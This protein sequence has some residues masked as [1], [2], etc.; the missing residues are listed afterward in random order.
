V[1]KEL[2]YFKFEPGAWDTGNIQMCSR[3]SKGLFIDVCSLYWSRLGELPYALALQKLCNGSKDALQELIDHEIIGIIE[4]QIVIE[5]LDEQLSEFNQTSEK[6][7]KAANKRWKDASALHVDS[8]SNAIREEKK[9]EEKIRGEEIPTPAV[10]DLKFLEAFDENTCNGYKL[11]FR[12]TDLGR[13]LEL[14]KLKCDNDKQTYYHRDTAGLRTAFQYQLK[15]S[16]NGKSKG[17]TDKR[18]QASIDRKT[19]FAERVNQR[20]SGEQL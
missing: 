11:A 14:F 19:A 4:G 17:F 5:F 2:P 3:D 18:E 8:K 20:N 9:R 1:A 16:R 12:N 7:R 10:F 15:N 6:R 13:E